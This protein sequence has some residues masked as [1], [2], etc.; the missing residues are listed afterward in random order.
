[1]SARVGAIR[2][3][4]PGHVKDGICNPN[5]TALPPSRKRDFRST[6]RWIYTIRYYDGPKTVWSQRGT[7]PCDSIKILYGGKNE[8]WR[9]IPVGGVQLIK[10]LGRVMQSAK[11]F[12][13]FSD[14]IVNMR[15][16]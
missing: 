6:K 11:F 7:G 2:S 15:L 14:R 3:V 5:F 4:L 9:R 8:E 13:Q 1:M 16:G 12:W 10:S